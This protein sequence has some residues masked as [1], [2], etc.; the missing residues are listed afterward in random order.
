LNQID[1]PSLMKK[2]RV[3]IVD[4]FETVRKGIRAI[5]TSRSD[6]EICAEARN[7]EEGVRMAKLLE[8]DIVFMDFT[9]PVMDGLEASKQILRLFPEMPIIMFSMHGSDVVA[10]ESK[11][12][13][14][15]GFISK[16]ES[17]N[18]LLE[19]LDKVIR[20]EPFFIFD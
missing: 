11:K 13:G 15:R 6:I 16:S 3:L 17:G 9:M 8:P 18:K 7:G 10:E 5:V 2:L 4:D 1:S 12:I 14:L 19:A 20:K